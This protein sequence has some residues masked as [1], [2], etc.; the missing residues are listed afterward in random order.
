MTFTEL[1]INCLKKDYLKNE[2][3]KELIEKLIGKT[4]KP[5]VPSKKSNGKKTDGILILGLNPAGD[6]VDAN[7]E[8]KNAFYMY[9]TPSSYDDDKEKKDFLN[10]LNKNNLIYNK[11]F[12]PIY[13]FCNDIYKDKDNCKDKC[14]W[15]WC[16][17]NEKSLEK[18]IQNYDDNIKNNI[19]K[20]YEEEKNKGITIY[21]GDILYIHE[22]NSKKINNMINEE[23][24]INKL[25]DIIN[26]HI[27]TLKNKGVDIKFVYINNSYVSKLINDNIV[28]I[29]DVNINDENI[30]NTMYGYPYENECIPM[31]FGRML[32]GGIDDFSR[33]RLIDEIKSKIE[34]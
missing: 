16:N 4:F 34:K 6:I 14:K 10:C 30:S 27:E 3:D 31:F 20:L 12:R 19:T 21:I 25:E 22:T 13:Q 32:S 18:S 23:T 1:T 29:N 8:R 24:L 15:D 5:R 11:Y 2:S 17:M 26:K 7:Q 28:N 9:S 33:Q